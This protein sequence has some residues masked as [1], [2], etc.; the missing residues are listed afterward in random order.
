MIIELDDFKPGVWYSRLKA[1]TRLQ[2]VELH[3][4][5]HLLPNHTLARIMR[6]DKNH[7]IVKTGE[8]TGKLVHKSDCKKVNDLFT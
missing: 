8:H 2:V 5:L 4:N 3:E 1:G 7:Y 6:N